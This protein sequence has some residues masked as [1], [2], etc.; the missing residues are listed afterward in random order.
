[1]T[2]NHDR[3]RAAMRVGLALPVGEDPDDGPRAMPY[4]QIRE[5]ALTA[6]AAG[7]DSVWAAD[8][9]LYQP[10]EGPLIGFWE[11]WTLMSALAEATSR[12]ELGHLVLA[13][14]FRNP[15]LLAW[16]ANTLDEVSGGRFVLGLGSGWNE[17]EFRA[18]GFDFE[19]RVGV[20]EDSLGVVL[21]LLQEGRVA[22]DGRFARGH[23]ELRPPAR[24]ERRLPVL[25]ASK[26]PRMQRLAARH[27][28]RWN[29]AWYG[30]PAEPFWERREGLYAAC[31]E[32][33]REPTEIEIT[34]GLSILDEAEAATEPDG[35]RFLTGEPSQIAEGL[36]AWQDEGA[37]EV[38][39]R[40]DP[41]TPEMVERVAHAADL[42]RARSA[43]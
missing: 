29:T 18:A 5:L 17:P 25:I 31:R 13:V 22:F 9:I 11:A 34:V 23:A 28:D 39:C 26:Q 40:L 1:M 41:S 36:R 37:A 6:E 16:M 30:R 43:A 33:G 3:A 2:T 32:I 10:P 21:P 42:L 27:A 19:H 15:T 8:H 7:L 38:M 4:S 35:T 14:P 20:F 12:V 24:R